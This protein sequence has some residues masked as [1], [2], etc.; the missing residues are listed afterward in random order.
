MTRATQLIRRSL[1][2][3]L[4]AVGVHGAGAL[5]VDDVDVSVEV[6]ALVITDVATPGGAVTGNTPQI[7]RV[8]VRNDTSAPVSGVSV[9]LAGVDD[10][11]PRTVTVPAAGE[12]TVTFTVVACRSGANVVTAS[13]AASG[14]VAAPVTGVLTVAPGSTCSQPLPTPSGTLVVT[15]DAGRVVDLVAVALAGLPAAPAGTQLPY[16]AISF[17]VLDLTPGQSVNVRITVPGEATDYVKL[18][19]GGWVSVPGAVRISGGVLV[20]LTD[21]GIGDADGVVNGIIV[22]PG[23]VVGPLRQT[24]TTTAKATPI[25]DPPASPTTVAGAVAATVAASTTV[26]APAPPAGRAATGTSPT[27]TGTPSGAL[28]QTGNDG[29]ALVWVGLGVT[30]LGGALLLTRR[31][32]TRPSPPSMRD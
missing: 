4:L 24:S 2:A 21:G 22:D 16:G 26:S 6:A 29:F 17:R 15:T 28:P 13:A 23:A 10:D 32:V 9:D 27:N 31:R 14:V 11:G 30:A 8:S 25:T 20:T 18:T 5:A 19:G 3:G 1:L 7:V 12:V